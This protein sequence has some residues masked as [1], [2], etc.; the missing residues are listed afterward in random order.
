MTCRDDITEEIRQKLSRIEAEYNVRVIF[1]CESGSRAWGFASD[2]SDYDVRFVYVRPA[3]EYLRLEETRDVIE[4]ELNDI[5]DINGW[6]IQKLLRLLYKCNPVIFE[7]ADSPIVYKKTEEWERVQKILPDYFS[8]MKMLY[9][10]RSIAKNNIRS[11]FQGDEVNLK[12]Y[13]Y[14][15]RPLLA[16][17]WILNKKCPP[18][19][20]F[21]ALCREVLPNE[22][23]NA[24]ETLVKIKKGAPE[25]QRGP[26]IPQLDIFIQNQLSE[27]EAFLDETARENEKNGGWDKMNEVFRGMVGADGSPH[28]SRPLR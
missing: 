17:R 3:A 12:K 8:K 7:W 19:T 13:F 6:D 21:S 16:C 25:K 18:P 14:V 2:D 9:H 1:A 23:K 26:H 4:Y 10:Y 24:V 28:L 20:A 15:L 5:Y 11:H 27:A 22:L